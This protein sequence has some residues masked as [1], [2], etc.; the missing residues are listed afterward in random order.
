MRRSEA[1]KARLRAAS[2]ALAVIDS[3]AHDGRG[4]A[5]LDGKAVFIEGALPGEQVEFRYTAIRRDYAEGQVS[6][7][8]AASAQ[9]VEPQCT[10][11]AVCGGCRLQH[12]ALDQQITLK[13]ALLLEQLRRI[14][15]AEPE[16][17][18]PPLTGEAWGYRR[19]ARLGVKY[20]AKKGKVLVGFREKSSSLLAEIES[21]P[22]L[23]PSVGDRIVDIA[24][25]IEG[26]SIR[27]RLP[28]IE[29]AVG[30]DA[31]VLVFRL[32]ADPSA[33]DLERLKD[34]G[35]AFGFSIRLQRHGPD[36]V[37]PIDPER[38]AATL[39]YSLPERGLRFGF[40]PGDFTQVNQDI[41]RRMVGHALDLLEVD[42]GHEVLDLFCGLGNFTLPIAQ[43]ARHVIGL[44]GDKAL[45]DKARHNAAVNGIGNAE[46]HVAD[47]LQR[48]DGAPWIDRRFD[49]VLLDPSRAGAQE[50]LRYVPHWQAPRIVYISC[51]PA[52]LARDTSVL[53]HQH[54]YRLT[55]AGVMDMFPHTAHVESVAVFVR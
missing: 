43:Q 28:Q 14:G 45:I 30:D 27:E 44:E 34:F 39:S 25:L 29:V 22:V 47:L 13:Q 55:T 5:H 11:Y 24:R 53:V 31:T 9:R 8:L 21:C 42:A 38:A 52:T 2:P 49:R 40:A 4:V 50:V 10:R 23:H 41:N 35:A 3:V 15:K 19:K 48:H 36:S 16:S 37:T 32:L 26:L 46:F 20:V 12:L 6:R 7:I 1:R 18:L 54:R 51:N 17:V 33:G